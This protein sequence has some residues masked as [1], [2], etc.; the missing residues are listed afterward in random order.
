[1]KHYLVTLVISVPDAPDLKD[2]PS[3]PSIWLW[4]TIINASGLRTPVTHLAT[5]PLVH[6]NVPP[7]VPQHLPVLL[8]NLPLTPQE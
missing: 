8:H 6:T 3:D 7:A 2:G 1:M 4:D 5:F